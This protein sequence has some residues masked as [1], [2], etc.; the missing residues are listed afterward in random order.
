M[1]E[2]SH[3]LG[4]DGAG[5]GLGQEPYQGI[6]LVAPRLRQRNGNLHIPVNP[7]SDSIKPR[8]LASRRERILDRA[9]AALSQ[10]LVDRLARSSRID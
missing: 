2:G 1:L 4:Q 3:I 10:I 5:S 7:D 9:D 6:T 8:G